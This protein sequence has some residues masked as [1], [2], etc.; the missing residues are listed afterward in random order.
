M[1]GLS[2]GHYT[3][4]SKFNDGRWYYCNDSQIQEV[5]DPQQTVS[6][7]AYCLWYRKIGT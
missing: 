5:A 3:A 4:F 1:G 6:Q 2:G 7:A